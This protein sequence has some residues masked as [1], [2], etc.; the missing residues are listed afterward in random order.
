MK[1]FKKGDTISLKADQMSGRTYEVID[2]V[3]GIAQGK[4]S[5][6]KAGPWSM[7]FILGRPEEYK[8]I[9]RPSK[10]DREIKQLQQLL[11]ETQDA[12]GSSQRRNRENQ[13]LADLKLLEAGLVRLDLLRTHT[14]AS[15]QLSGD[16]SHTYFEV[17]ILVEGHAINEIARAWK[18]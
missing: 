17:K 6:D 12:L 4:R 1:K 11:K 14:I 8:L 10:K 5:D 3:N 16:G 13:Q 9:Y 2:F 18:H 7:P 15:P